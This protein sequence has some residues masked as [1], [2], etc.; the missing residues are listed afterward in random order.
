MQKQKQI[1]IWIIICSM[2][3]FFTFSMGEGGINYILITVMSIF[4]VLLIFPYPKIEK[5]ELIFYILLGLMLIAA[6]RHEKTFRIATILYSLMFVSTFIYYYR[7]LKEN[8]V[9]KELYLKI[10]KFLIW[11][12]F[13]T[14]LVQ[15]F[16]LILNIPIFNY[17]IGEDSSLKFN[18]LASEPSYF[19]KIIILLMLSYIST[20]EITLGRAYDLIKD[21]KVD[22]VIWLIFLYQIF[23]CGSS[24]AILLLLVLLLKYIKM[25][26]SGI[27]FLIFMI[28]GLFIVVKSYKP[29]VTER[30]LTV[31]E[32]FFTFDEDKIFLAD[33]SGAFRIV[34][35]IIYVK[36]FDTFDVDLWFGK[37]IDY[38]KRVMPD[39]MMALD[40]VDFNVGLFPSFLWDSGI[41]AT[42]VLILI[43]FKF[44]IFKK[45]FF[46]FLLFFVIILDAPFNTQL[47]WITLIF[48][49]TN[50]FLKN[51]Y[52]GKRIIRIKKNN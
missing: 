47:F 16:C 23:L 46:D 39:L 2:A 25:K 32:V 30:L 40:D 26:M 21:T 3:T 43:V 35:T 37:G 45:S 15:Q 50:K 22:K 38:T 7:L 14:M 5:H 9:T 11:I 42:I 29:I 48:M 8:V 17:R 18:S 19:G 49:S 4:S 44:A 24:F 36:K 12:F 41:F 51:K 52:K 31:S 10:I 33:Q 6:Y 28:I 27:V 20:K 1:N 34:P 13:I